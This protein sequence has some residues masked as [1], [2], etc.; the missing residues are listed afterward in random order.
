M[1]LEEYRR[2]VVW[3]SLTLSEALLAVG[4]VHSIRLRTVPTFIGA[5]RSFAPPTLTPRVARLGEH[6]RYPT[7]HVTTEYLLEDPQQ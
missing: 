4:A 2:V 6:H 1:A 7:G 3:G 5:G